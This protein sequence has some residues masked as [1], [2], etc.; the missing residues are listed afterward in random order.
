VT[1]LGVVNRAFTARSISVPVAAHGLAGGSGTAFTVDGG[2][3]Q[4]VDGD[5]AVDV[6]PRSFRLLVV[7]R[8]PG[9]LWTDSAVEASC[10]GDAAACQGSLTIT[11]RGPADVPGFMYL[12][13]PSPAGV[14]IDGNPLRRAESAGPEEYAYDEASGLLS[15]TYSHD[16]ERRID[17][18]W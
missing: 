18:R 2:S 5:F 9:L 13:T 1:Y 8:D 17:V 12:A 7:R 14:A 15:L 4:M 6:P 11:A 16:G 10:G 3:A